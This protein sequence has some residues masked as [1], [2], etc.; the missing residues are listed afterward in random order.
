MNA[1]QE[2]LDT[3]GTSN[4]KCVDISFCEDLYTEKI[5]ILKVGYTKEEYEEF[6]SKLDF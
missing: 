5:I 2:F 3:V 4:V 1:R 6:L